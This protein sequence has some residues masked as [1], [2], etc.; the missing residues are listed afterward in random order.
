MNENL[1]LLRLRDA[2]RECERHVHHLRHA[3]SALNPILPLAGERFERLNDDEVQAMDQ[4][5]LRFTKLQDCMGV[6]LFSALLQYLEE[7]YDDRPMLDKLN[8]LE[9]LGFIESAEKWQE[10]RVLRNK[11]AHDYPDDS[12]KNAMQINLACEVA[13]DLFG[14]LKKIVSK[15]QVEY[16]EL[17]LGCLPETV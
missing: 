3:L 5:V 7:P 2:W 9:K 14:I 17:A 13:S 11:F 16:P 8:R 1:A 6:R 4:F 10:I 15:L 12:E